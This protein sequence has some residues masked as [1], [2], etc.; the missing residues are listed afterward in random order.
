[1]PYGQRAGLEDV[2]GVGGGGRENQTKKHRKLHSKSTRK[3]KA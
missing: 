2:M 1:M 3:R